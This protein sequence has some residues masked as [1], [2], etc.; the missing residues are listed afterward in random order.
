L[1]HK[2]GTVQKQLWKLGR[3]KPDEPYFQPTLPRFVGPIELV[4]EVDERGLDESHIPVKD[5][6]LG[7]T[8]LVPSLRANSRKVS[9]LNTGQA[10][11]LAL[12]VG[13]QTCRK[14][15]G[16]KPGAISAGNRVFTNVSLA[17]LQVGENDPHETSRRVTMLD[18]GFTGQQ[19]AIYKGF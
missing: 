11:E 18:S 17:A 1:D 19:L 10:I 13:I 2:I 14:R 3:C 4:F 7:E 15:E 16:L 12:E 8:D 6:L 5:F 9:H